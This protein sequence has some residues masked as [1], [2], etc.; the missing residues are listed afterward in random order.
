MTAMA[1]AAA[2]AARAA[3]GAGIVRPA[4][5]GETAVTYL[6]ACSVIPAVAAHLI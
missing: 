1:D 2:T 5:T 4:D 6:L 3:A